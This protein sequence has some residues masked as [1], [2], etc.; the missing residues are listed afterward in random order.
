MINLL[1]ICHTYNLEY[2][3]GEMFNKD[4]NER[5]CDT[6]EDRVRL[7]QGEQKVYGK[8]SIPRGTYDIEIRYSPKFKMDTVWVKDVPQFKW[9]L[10]HWGRTEKQSHGCILC[11]QKSGDGALSN[12]GMTKHLV[13][14]LK[15][16]GGKGTIEI[17]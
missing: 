13:Q 7:D 17:K 4:L 10:L 6:L 16:H 8:T 3:E 14:L 1:V 9:I 12:I 2:T 5:I 15:D 11:G